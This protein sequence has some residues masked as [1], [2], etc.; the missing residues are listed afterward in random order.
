MKA[1][2][3]GF[4]V[5]VC[6]MAYGQSGSVAG[7]SG[8]YVF[9]PSVMGLRQI[10]GIPGAS[11]MSDPIDLGITAASVE[12]A[13]RSDSAIA[14]ASDGSVHLFRLKDGAATEIAV[15]L[16][17]A[18]ARIVYS[19]SGIAAALFGASGAQVLSGLPDNA[20]IA[21]LPGVLGVDRSEAAASGTRRAKA[22]GVAVSDDGRY[23]L[24]SRGSSIT[25]T[26][27]AGEGRVL[28]DAHGAAA[29]SFS[30]GSH[31]AAVVTGGTLSV[32]QDVAGAST[33]QDFP[34]AGAPAGLAFS[35][36]GAKVLM[37]GPRTVTILDRN[38]GDRKLANCDCQIGQL[39]PMGAL[40][41]VN[42]AGAGPLWLLDASADTPRL[43]FVPA[44][45][46]V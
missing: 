33:R 22:A 12:V 5:A 15:S 26:G 34:N 6:G 28:A 46:G 24:M 23:L 21:N 35:V 29:V 17:A 31:D 40:F 36:D 9:D 38:T 37:A 41:R 4:L 13:P 10:R 11:L 39:T 32:F 1:R 45:P 2:A 3:I 14:V 8:G 44:K 30:P 25:L 27:P 19:P 7:P 20:S 42:D 43:L 16:A 18:P